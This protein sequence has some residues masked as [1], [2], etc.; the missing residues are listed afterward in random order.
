MRLTSRRPASQ[1]IG[2]LRSI[3]AA[4]RLAAAPAGESHRPPTSQ[5]AR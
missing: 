1:A 5:R 2:S 3:K 4:A